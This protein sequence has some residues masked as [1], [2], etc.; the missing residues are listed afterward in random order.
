MYALSEKSEVFKQSLKNI[1][2]DQTQLKNV[3]VE[4]YTKI[5]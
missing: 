2:S 4:M 3:V 1:K 5:K